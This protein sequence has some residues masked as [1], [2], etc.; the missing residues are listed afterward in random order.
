MIFFFNK[1]RLGNQLFHFAFLMGI[2]N[3]GEAMCV[4]GMHELFELLDTRECLCWHCDRYPFRMLFGKLLATLARLRIIPTIGLLKTAAPSRHLPPVITRKGVFSAIRFVRAD[5]FQSE[6]YLPINY[7]EQLTVRAEHVA[8]ARA[9]LAQFPAECKLVFVHVRRGDYLTEKYAGIQGLALPPEY[10]HQAIA[11][12]RSRLENPCFIVLSDDIPYCQ[13]LFA[14]YSDFHYSKNP[15]AVDFA[16]MTLCYAGII[17]NSS[18]S[19]WGSK[20]APDIR[21][22]LSPRYWFGWRSKITYPPFIQAED[23]IQVDF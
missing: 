19:W 4:I 2:R 22:I 5:Y 18:Y 12:V 13:Q 15:P 3:A 7:K 11:L 10:Y 17:S 23:F 1:G 8:K 16:I 9:C 6:Q 14:A 20:L 21:L